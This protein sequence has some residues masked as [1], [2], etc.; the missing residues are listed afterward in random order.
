MK[1][2]N[3]FGGRWEISPWRTQIL[4]EDARYVTEGVIKGVYLA[5]GIAEV[6]V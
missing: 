1:K 5:N 2:K 4:R 6:I 3:R